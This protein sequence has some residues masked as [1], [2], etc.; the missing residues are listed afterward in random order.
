MHWCD[1]AGNTGT[2]ERKSR[3]FE[4]EDPMCR[5]ILTRNSHSGVNQSPEAVPHRTKLHQCPE[6]LPRV[7]NVCQG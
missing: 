3:I 5:G 4:I 2:P 7:H 6:P 1:Q